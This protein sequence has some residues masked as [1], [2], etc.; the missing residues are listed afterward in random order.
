MWIAYWQCDGDLQYEIATANRK[1]TAEFERDEFV[2]RMTHPEVGVW[3]T[4]LESDTGEVTPT[5]SYN[6]WRAQLWTPSEGTP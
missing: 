4:W 5:M 2:K 3:F 1:H 6:E